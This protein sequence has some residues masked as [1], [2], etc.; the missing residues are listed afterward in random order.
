MQ[1]LLI[2]YLCIILQ[3]LLLG[4]PGCGKSSLAYT[5]WRSLTDAS[6]STDDRAVDTSSVGHLSLDWN[7]LEFNESD[8]FEVAVEALEE[9]TVSRATTA[10]HRPPLTCLSMCPWQV[11]MLPE[12]PARTN[13]TVYVDIQSAAEACSGI[14]VIGT[15]HMKYIAVFLRLTDTDCRHPGGEPNG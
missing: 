4:A 10:T 1:N 13:K 5:L 12:E 2:L 15:I 14:S 6:V 3:I 7:F 9:P 8:S 11:L